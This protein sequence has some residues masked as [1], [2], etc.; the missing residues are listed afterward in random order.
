MHAYVW[1]IK[2][3][4]VSSSGIT[5]RLVQ[6]HNDWISDMGGLATALLQGQIA[7][8]TRTWIARDR[9]SIALLYSTSLCIHARHLRYIPAAAPVRGYWT[10]VKEC[11]QRAC[12]I[13]SRWKEGGDFFSDG[14]RVIHAGGTGAQRG[15]AVFLDEE[16]AKGV[17]STATELSWSS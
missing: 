12:K 10:T 11:N 8:M 9:R 16:A 2:S 13:T 7:R 6:S 5:R 15:V 14:V 17:I 1:F 3:L 4:R